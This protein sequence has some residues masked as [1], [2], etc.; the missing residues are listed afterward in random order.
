MKLYLC[1]HGDSA[2]KEVN[3]EKPLTVKGI[4]EVK[5]IG[6][7]LAEAGLQFSEIYHSGKLRAK[8]TSEILAKAVSF[9]GTIA[10]KKGIEPMDLV[11]PLVDEVTT[12]YQDNST[13]RDN[14]TN[15]QISEANILI[16][17][18]LPFMTKLVS[19]LLTRN[20]NNIVVNF[21]TGSVVCLERIEY[22]WVLN[23]M[24]RPEL[25]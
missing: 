7:M 5:A 20:E 9:R 21:V 15:K 24:L 12:F 2:P 6:R 1:Q 19:Q 3:P 8:Q 25:L 11:L 16:V 14:S 10:I 17:G 4:Q 18:H 23:W 22:Q 13:N